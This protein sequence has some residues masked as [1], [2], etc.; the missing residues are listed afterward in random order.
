MPLRFGPYRL[1]KVRIGDRLD[2]EYAGTVRVVAISDAPVQWPLGVVRGHR[3][4]VLCGQLVRAVKRESASDVAKAWG[5]GR[6]LVSK[7]RKALRVKGAEGDRLRLSAA[8]KASDPARARKIAK[9]KRGKPRP[10]HVIEAMAKARKG[11][12]HS[13]AT[14]AKMSSSHQ[15]RG[16]R[17]PWLKP[18][19]SEAED[20]LVRTKPPSKVAEATGRSLKAIYLRRIKLGLTS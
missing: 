10:R 13:K 3:I 20:G 17:P 5:I 1:P 9:A 14:R 8:V 19:W 2:C 18:A 16:S 4:P 12:K 7:W 15:L 11:M 6:G